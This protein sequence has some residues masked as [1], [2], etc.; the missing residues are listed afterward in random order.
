MNDNILTSTKE[1]AGLTSDYDSFDNEIVMYINSV[2][3]VLKQ[4]GVGPSSGFIITDTNA[5]WDMYIPD[6]DMLRESVKAY[7]GA[8]V[9]MQFDPPASSS[10]ASAFT[11]MIDELEFR[12]NMEAE[13][14]NAEGGSSGG[15]GGV[16]DY[17]DLT[18][19]PSING[20]TLIGNYNE[21]DPTVKAMTP[22]VVDDIW[23]EE[24]DKEASE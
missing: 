18:N 17:R 20:E 4:L 5:T 7:M 9:R 13:G 23:D 24:F 12:L 1:L 16:T 19:L 14:L 3:L 2:F 11:N 10:I 21:K 8:K 6:N 22:T 15:G